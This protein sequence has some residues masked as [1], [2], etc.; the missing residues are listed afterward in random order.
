VSLQVTTIDVLDA[1][2]LADV[3]ATYADALRLHRES[4]NRLNVYPVPDGDTGTNMTLTVDSAVAEIERIRISGAERGA[5]ADMSATCKAISHGSLMGARGNSGV[6]LCQIL[7]GMSATFAALP[8]V[9]P[10]ELAK[11]F[12]EAAAAARAGVMRPVEGTILTVMSAA[13]DGAAAA[14]AAG[15]DLVTATSA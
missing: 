7:R 11:G 4:L 12:T 5:H 1:G 10:A 13:A 14:L 15:G 3:V 6:I 8:E 2:G 9:G